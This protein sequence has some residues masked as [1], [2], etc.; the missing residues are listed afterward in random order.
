MA[1]YTVS[2]GNTINATDINQL[3]NVLMQ[4]SGG[5]EIGAYYLDGWASGSGQEI[6]DW[7][8]TLSRGAT[9]VSVS[10]DTS[11]A[12]PYNI[13]SPSTNSLNSNGF[14]VYATSN[15]SS[16]K[17]YVGGKYTLQY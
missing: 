16:S 1:L 10:I 7:V 6:G 14:H 11:I 8:S 3:V 17:C 13:N 5:Q 2:S 9:P 12:S 4:P 15:G